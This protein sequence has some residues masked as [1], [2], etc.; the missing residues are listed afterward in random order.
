MYSLFCNFLVG[1]STSP[2]PCCKKLEKRKHECTHE[3]CDASCN[4]KKT[5]MSSSLLPKDFQHHS[6][7]PMFFRKKMAS[8]IKPQIFGLV[9]KPKIDQTAQNNIFPMGYDSKKAVFIIKK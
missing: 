5:E 6:H 1:I 7:L 2:C 9:E 3:F 4:K 8:G